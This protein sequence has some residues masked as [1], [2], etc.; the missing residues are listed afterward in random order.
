MVPGRKG[1]DHGRTSA[2]KLLLVK[3]SADRPGE[4][5]TSGARAIRVA[6]ADRQPVVRAGLRTLLDGKHGI[7]VVAE[8]ADGSGTVAVVR[9]FVPDVVLLDAD[10]PGL[11]VPEV[12]RRVVRGPHRGGTRV[13]VLATDDTDELLFA[14]LRA[15]ASGFLLK[16]SEPRDLV[17]AVRAVA[18]GQARLSPNATDRLIAELAAHPRPYAPRDE[19]LE[20]LTPRER[21][22]VALV[23]AG[24]SNHEIAERLVISRATAK[25]HVS[26]A[27]S[28]LDVRDRAQLVAVAHRAGLG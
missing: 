28:K 13:M 22:V 7:V 11:D 12:T 20:T 24:L 23:A 14:A 5:P 8:A 16:D 17:E 25:T 15:G 19:Q 10:L 18:G 21:E 3:P 1:A 6:I 26:R 4:R 27:L 2:R 9:A